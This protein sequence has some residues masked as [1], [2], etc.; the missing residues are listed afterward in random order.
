[1]PKPL[2]KEKR[3]VMNYPKGIAKRKVSAGSMLFSAQAM[4]AVV[5]LSPM[6]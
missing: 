2:E 1:M 3:E 4:V 6:K 5:S